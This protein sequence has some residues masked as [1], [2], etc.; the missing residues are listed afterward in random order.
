MPATLATPGRERRA[1]RNAAAMAPRHT[2][3][4]AARAAPTATGSTPS[5]PSARAVPVVPN[6]TDA[7]RTRTTDMVRIVT[8]SEDDRFGPRCKDRPVIPL[9]VS[10]SDYHTAGEPFRLVTDP[11]VALPGSSVADRRAR[12]LNSPD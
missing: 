3:P 12:A 6:K 5:S 4:T 10:T 11:P 9:S 1:R 2:P 7:R 8:Q